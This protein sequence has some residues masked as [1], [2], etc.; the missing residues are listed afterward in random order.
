MNRVRHLINIVAALAA[1]SLPTACT[2]PQPAS[3][4][5]ARGAAVAAPANREL[6]NSERIE[7]AF[8][9]YGIEVLQSSPRV[10]ISNL[11][12]TEGERRITRTFAVV[13]YP[14][15]IPP[16]LA[17]EH[18]TILGGGSM[19]AVLAAAGWSVLKSHLHY[20]ERAA[21]PK[22]AA[23]MAIEPGTT[24]AE[25]VYVLEVAKGGSR[26]PYATLAEIHH[27]DYLR[28]A[29]VA[30][31]YGPVRRSAGDRRVLAAMRATAAHAERD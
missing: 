27:P 26:H 19:G 11:Y 1:L 22:L 23:L 13:R 9:S 10:R 20:G 30:A 29:D 2:Q 16:D 14:D 24:L 28:R 15:E 6:L 17:E 21:T 3:V 25:H 7:M 31:I 8:G 4:E 18:R 5:T 12:S